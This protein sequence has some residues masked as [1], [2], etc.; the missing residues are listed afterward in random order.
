MGFEP[1]PPDSRPTTDTPRLPGQTFNDGS[2]SRQHVLQK[3]GIIPGNN[4][5]NA[6]KQMDST[7]IRRADKNVD[8]I[9]KARKTIIN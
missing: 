9:K 3:L 6:I 4:F 1:G 5:H 7:K 2:T 8:L